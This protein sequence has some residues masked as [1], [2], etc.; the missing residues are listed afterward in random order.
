MQQA[1]ASAAAVD[2]QPQEEVIW[3]NSLMDLDDDDAPIAAAIVNHN[4]A[5]AQPATDAICLSDVGVL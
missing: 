5:V 4:V 3:D 2:A 1:T